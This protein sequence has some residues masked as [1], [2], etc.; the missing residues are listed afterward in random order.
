VFRLQTVTIKKSGL[1]TAPTSDLCRLTLWQKCN[2]YISTFLGLLNKRNKILHFN[3][4]A[5]QPTLIISEGTME[6]EEG[7]INSGKWQLS[8]CIQHVKNT[9][10]QN[11]KWK[12]YI[13]HLHLQNNKWKVTLISVRKTL[14][15]R[16]LQSKDRMRYVKTTSVHQLVSATRLSD[17]SSWTLFKEF[18][19]ESCRAGVRFVKVKWQ[20]YFTSRSKSNFTC[21]HKFTA[22]YL[23]A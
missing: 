21:P 15:R 9:R 11:K 5:V 19:I 8:K 4:H 22:L 12:L 10:K 17:G 2:I 6:E 1:Q 16:S 7:G 13:F 3:K 18:F 14:C 20:T 23:R